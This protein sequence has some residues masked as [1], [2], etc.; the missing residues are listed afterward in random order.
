MD[1]S[2]LNINLDFSSIAGY[3][4]LIAIAIG[5]FLC[6]FGYKLKRVAFVIIWFAIGYYLMSLL[7]PKLTNDPTWL[8]LLPIAAGVVLGVFGFSLEKLCIFAVAAYAVSTTLIDTFLLYEPLHIALAIGAGVVVGLLAVRLI[9][10]F[11][12]VTTAFSGAKLIAKYSLTA[13]PLA[14]YPSFP[15]ILLA[16]AAIGILFQ[17][18]SCKHLN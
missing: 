17:F 5:V 3:E 15:I 16:A 1:L 2:N 14:H 18:K 13:L 11:G 4:T 7:A 12:I 6:L 8:Q 9:K 10:P